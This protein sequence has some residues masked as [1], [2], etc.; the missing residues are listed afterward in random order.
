MAVV[1]IC[2]ACETAMLP[3][4]LTSARPDG[5]AAPRG[6]VV[7]TVPTDAVLTHPAGTCRTPCRVSYPEPVEVLVAKEGYAPLRLN[8]PVGARDTTFEL[9]PVGRTAEVEEVALPA[10]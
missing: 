3:D 7:A 10:L 9:Q 2:A 8:I 6:T 5:D 1:L 4:G